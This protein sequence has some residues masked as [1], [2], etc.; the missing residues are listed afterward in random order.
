MLPAMRRLPIFLLAL[1]LLGGCP[2]VKLSG[3]GVKDGSVGPTGLTLTAQVTVQETEEVTEEGASSNAGRA[4]IAV[5]LPTGWAVSAARLKSPQESTARR[6][7]P[8]P[9]T[10][11]QFG[12]TFPQV[13]G[14]WWAFGSNSQSVP[15]G[16]WVHEVELDLTYPKRTKAGELGVSVSLLQETLDEV[17]APQIYDVAIQ[18]KKATL[19]PRAKEAPAMPGPDPAAGNSDKASAG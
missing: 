8:I 15:T 9:Q 6:L 11:I 12:E 1:A 13:P 14:Q 2:T 5:Y 10:A 17:P 4:L 18:G 16:T 7:T 3:V 19:E